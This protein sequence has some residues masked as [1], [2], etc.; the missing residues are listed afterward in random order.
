MTIRKY[1]INLITIIVCFFLI[2]STAIG[3]EE[4]QQAIY[5]FNG[6]SGIFA[7]D[8]SSGEI[9]ISYNQDKLFTPASLVKIFTLLAGLE[10]LGEEYRYPTAFYFSSSV[11]GYIDGDVFIKG[12]GDPTQSPEVIRKIAQDLVTKY[13]IQQISGD[14]VLD[15]S[16]ICP[17]E[18]LGRGWMWDDQNPLIGS[19]IIKGE[20]IGEPRI[21]YYKKMSTVWGEIF[22]R[23]LRRQGVKFNGELR[24]GRL[25]EN[26][27]VKS[28]FYSET[29]EKILAYMMRMSDNQSA[30][31][32]F[33]TLALSDDIVE[34]STI[35]HSITSFSDIIFEKL[36]FQWGDD[37]IIVDG[38]GLSEYNLITPAQVVKAITYL[39]D[40]YD[41]EV[42]KYFANTNERGTIRQR[43]P[44]QVWGKTG[45][46][47]SASGLAGI[48]TT[49]SNRDVVFCLMENNFTGEQNNP[50]TFENNI[51]EFIYENY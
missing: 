50:K 6:F 47:P 18:F 38:C 23:E 27:P 8:L 1:F 4:I 16:I 39:Y 40:Q 25:E 10:T 3:N 7:Q 51:I 31:A 13:N 9:L 37:Y 22:H 43:F 32:V 28:I 49:K 24:L 36:L 33:R 35:S 48:F 46:L 14:I 12:Y 21:S 17:G 30:E 29:L 34:I 45:S 41:T 5:Q 15:D 42:L 11:P 19:F 2:T 26:I 44:F 20:S